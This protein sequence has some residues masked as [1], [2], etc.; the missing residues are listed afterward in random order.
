MDRRTC[1]ALDNAGDSKGVEGMTGSGVFMFP[2]TGIYPAAETIK[3]ASS[4]VT[5]PTMAKGSYRLYTHIVG[6]NR[7]ES[8]CDNMTA[9]DGAI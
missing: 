7:P 2:A 9:L 5:Q 3:P 1:G 8:R 6:C 4:S